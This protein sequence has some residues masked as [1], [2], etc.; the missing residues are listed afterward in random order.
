MSSSGT[1]AWRQL[2][3]AV[4]SIGGVVELSRSFADTDDGLVECMTC[5]VVGPISGLRVRTV[6]HLTDDDAGGRASTRISFACRV[7]SSRGTVVLTG[8]PT[9]PVRES[10]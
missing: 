4:G 9:V 1:S 6:H 8:D 5:G 10:S 3:T 7:C 2:A